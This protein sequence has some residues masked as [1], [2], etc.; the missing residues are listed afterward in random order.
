MLIKSKKKKHFVGCKSVR[1]GKAETLMNAILEQF[2]KLGLDMLKLVSMA[3][4]CAKVMTG[5]KGGVGALL[6]KSNHRLVQVHCVANIP[7]LCA[8]QACKETKELRNTKTL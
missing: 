2:S 1:D 4:D 6:R 8:G 3:S 5:H 7:A